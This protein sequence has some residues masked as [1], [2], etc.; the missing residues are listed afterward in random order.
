MGEEMKQLGRGMKQWRE[1]RKQWVG[2]SM[3]MGNTMCF[4][5]WVCR[6]MGMG[7]ALPYLH[8]TIPL[9]TGLQVLTASHMPDHMMLLITTT[10]T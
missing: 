5:L 10:T 3:G 1:G 8:N 4:C 6:G 2:H 9:P 7:M